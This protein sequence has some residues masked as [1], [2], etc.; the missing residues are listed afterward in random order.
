MN[1][2]DTY[3]AILTAYSGTTFSFAK[4][5]SYIDSALPGVF[6]TL[7]SDA[8]KCLETDK[9]CWE[10]DYLPVLNHVAYDDELRKTAHA[11]FCKA[12]ENLEHAIY[13]QF[14]KKIDVDIIFYLGLCNGAGWVTEY[15]GHNAILLGI[16]KIM[17]LNWCSLDDMYGLIYHELGHVYQGQ[18][19]ILKRTFDNNADSFLWQLFTEGVAMYFEQSLVGNADYYHQDKN[20]WKTWCDNHLEQIKADFSR[21]M[22]TMTFANQRYFG[23]WVMYDGHCDVGYYL[24]CRFVRCILSMYELDEIICFDIDRVKELFQQ[25]VQ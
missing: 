9:V 24:G 14:C 2:I 21:D 16:E 4:W 11:S 25:F 13:V 18:Y 10:T 1:I 15:H 23:D 12:T 19:G 3:P 6:Q 22:K 17:E 20:G 7:V 5:K 8:R